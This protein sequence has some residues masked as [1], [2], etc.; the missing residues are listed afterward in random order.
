MV[1]RNIPAKRLLSTSRGGF[2]VMELVIV[3]AIFSILLGVIIQIFLYTTVHQRRSRAIQEAQNEARVALEAVARELQN[4]QIDYDYYLGPANENQLTNQPVS[5]LALR[6]SQ[7]GIIRF[8]CV[9]N[10]AADEP[11]DPNTPD[12]GSVQLCR[13]SGCDAEEWSG[14][15]NEKLDVTSWQLWVGP[16]LNPFQRLAGGTS[17]QSDEQPWVTASVTIKPNQVDRAPIPDIRLQTTITTRTYL[18]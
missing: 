6:D 12:H 8:R 9:E 2:T 14:L 3:M 13:A 11:C 4:G 17:Y 18:R 16:L 5:V 10:G 15:V 1:L 7:G